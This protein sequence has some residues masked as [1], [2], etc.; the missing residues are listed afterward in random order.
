MSFIAYGLCND[1]ASSSG[2]MAP[3]L[4]QLINNG[5]ESLWTT[6]FYVII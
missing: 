4:A 5:F 6:W 1:A 2:Y 3:K